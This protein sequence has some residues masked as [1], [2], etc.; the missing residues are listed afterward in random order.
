MSAAVPRPKAEKARKSEFR[1][2]HEARGILAD[3]A[4]YGESCGHGELRGGEEIR[5]GIRSERLFVSA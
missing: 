5:N 3:R 2:G 4:S 1:G